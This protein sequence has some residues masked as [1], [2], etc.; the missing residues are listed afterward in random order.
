MVR[1]EVRW[2]GL[3]AGRVIER[4]TRRHPVHDATVHAD[5]YDAPGPVV[6]H[7]EHPVRVKDGRFAPKQIHTPETVLRVTEG[8][9]PGRSRGMWCRLLPSRQNASHHIP[10]DRN[11]ESQ[12]D[13]LREPADTPSL[14]SAVSCRRQ[15]R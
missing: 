8:G 12:G 11:T 2:Q 10:V 7:D 1:T 6:H 13:L 9:Q 15:Q 5:T 14:G 4:P 3:A